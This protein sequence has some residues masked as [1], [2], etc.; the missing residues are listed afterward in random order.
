[1]TGVLLAVGSRVE[2]AVTA[3]A[4]LACGAGALY[5]S[6][7]ASGRS[8]P[9]LPDSTRAYVSATVTW[10]ARSR[11]RHASLTPLIAAHFGWEASFHDRNRPGNSRRIGMVACQSSSATGSL[12]LQGASPAL[13]TYNKP[14]QRPVFSLLLVQVAV[15]CCLASSTIAQGPLPTTSADDRA[16]ARSILKELNR[17]QH[18]RYASGNVTTATAAMQ[19]RFL[20]AGFPAQDVQLLGPDPRKQNLVVRMRAAGSPRKNLFFSFAT[21]TLL[22]PSVRLDNRSLP[23]PWRRMATSTDAEPRT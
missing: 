10:A 13:R 14:M 20:D 18:D 5:V 17:D 23:T 1:M 11:S 7:V 22:K 4:V 6:Q 2:S 21:W 9:I 8:P 16:L 3:T 12:G 15:A 19:K